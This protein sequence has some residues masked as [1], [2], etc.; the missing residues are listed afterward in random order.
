MNNNIIGVSEKLPL[1]KTLPLSLQ[2]L[3]AMVGATILVPLLT[4]INPTTALLTSGLGT[5]AYIICTRGKLPSYVGSSFAFITPML[6]VTQMYGQDAVFGG[7]VICGIVYLIISIIIY[8]TGTNWIESVLPPVV[9]GSIVLVIGLGLAP[10]AIEWAGLSPNSHFEVIG[11]NKAIF[12][13]LLTLSVGIIGSVYFKGIFSVIPIL[14]AI[15]VGYIASIAIGVISKEQLEIIANTPIF[16]NPIQPHKVVFNLNAVILM[17]PVAFVT[18]AEHIGH[19]Y[20]ANNV[21]GTNFIKDPGLDKSILG[22]GIAEIIAG[23]LGG[24]PN[25]TYGENIGVMAITK[26]YSVWVIAWAA[27]L[28]IL[29]SFIGPLNAII[30]FIPQPVIGGVSILLFGIIASSGFRIFVENNLDFGSK[31]NLII[32]SVIIVIGLGKT[33]INLNLFGSQFSLSGVALASIV[34]II[35]NLILPNKNK[36]KT[37]ENSNLANAN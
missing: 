23:L 12:I 26:V 15:I 37:N 22:D 3:F 32:C 13:S 4:G 34:G 16:T 1:R 2:H 29:I 19:I 18:L 10:T 31:R 35:I 24:A 5:L 6:S 30:Q 17:V 11:K 33:T 9:V 28:A 8:K 14:C 7:I 36:E 27:I 25:T 21:V 20:V